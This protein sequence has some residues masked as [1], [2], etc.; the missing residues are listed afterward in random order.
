MLK[1]LKL[2]ARRSGIKREC[3]STWV[4]RKYGDM[5]IFRTLHDGTPGV[6]LPCVICRKVLDKNSIQWKAHCGQQWFKSTDD[7]I[8][9]SRP[10]Q[11]QKYKL[12][13]N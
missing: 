10:T 11:R 13:F 6:S 7:N 5:I 1:N 12:G 9:K 4:H 3:F 2:E 8:P